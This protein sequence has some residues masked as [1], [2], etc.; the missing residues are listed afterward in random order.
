MASRQGVEPCWLVLETGPVP[1]GEM[2]NW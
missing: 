2:C 1:D